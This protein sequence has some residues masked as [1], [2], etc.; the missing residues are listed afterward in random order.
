MQGEGATAAR[1]RDGYFARVQPSRY[2]LEF[3]AQVGECCMTVCLGSACFDRTIERNLRRLR[4]RER[5]THIDRYNAAEICRPHALRMA[6]HEYLG[7]ARSIRATQDVHLSVAQ[8]PSHVLEIVRKVY[9][10]VLGQ[11]GACTQL[12]FAAFYDGR[13][14]KVA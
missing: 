11:I 8:A 12:C 1:N 6:A 14:K 2:F 5:C 10:C 4:H 3:L 13:W 7:S 9:V